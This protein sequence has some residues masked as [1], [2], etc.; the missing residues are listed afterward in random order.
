MPLRQEDRLRETIKFTQNWPR[1]NPG[2]A[3][4]SAPGTGSTGPRLSIDLSSFERGAPRVP[5]G[6]RARELGLV[7][8][9]PAGRILL[10]SPT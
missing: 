3:D 4:F 1:D 8:K 2:G 9:A 10:A 6:A 7:A 5:C